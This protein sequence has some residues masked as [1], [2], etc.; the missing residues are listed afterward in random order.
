MVIYD[1]VKHAPQQRSGEAS[2]HIMMKIIGILDRNQIPYTT[3]NE[4][5]IVIQHQ[6]FQPKYLELKIHKAF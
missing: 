1:F 4:Y 3:E 5:R 6:D 2:N